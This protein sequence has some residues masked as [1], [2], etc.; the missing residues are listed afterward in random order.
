MVDKT[1]KP[2]GQ[3]V[4]SLWA[5]EDLGVPSVR[6][7]CEATVGF[8]KENTVS[9]GWYVSRGTIHFHC[10]RG[11]F[12]LE[13]LWTPRKK[14]SGFLEERWLKTVEKN[15]E[16]T[17]RTMKRTNQQKPWFRES[18]GTLSM[19]Q[20]P[21]LKRVWDLKKS[22]L[23]VRDSLGSK[24]PAAF[25]SPLLKMNRTKNTHTHTHTC[26]EQ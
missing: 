6:W 2:K 7:I 11:S 9:I 26:Q 18:R 3:K 23:R 5:T 10:F 20:E 24:T 21:P 8:A 13:N 25:C 22:L 17:P 14:G 1:G 4:D 19:R 12:F 16:S 15:G